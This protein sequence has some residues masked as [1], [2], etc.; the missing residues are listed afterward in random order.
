MYLLGVFSGWVWMWSPSVWATIIWGQLL[1]YYMPPGALHVPE[2][3]CIKGRN[4]K[5]VCGL[6]SAPLC[7]EGTTVALLCS[8]FSLSQIKHNYTFLLFIWPC[9]VAC[10]I[11]VPGPEI[12]PV[13]NLNHWATREVPYNCTFLTTIFQPPHNSD[14]FVHAIP[15]SCLFIPKTVYWTF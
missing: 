15:S 6:F 14:N 2:L 1:R 13:Q 4:G 3:C 9:Q 11:L 7:C 12:E 10:G 8:S 5:H